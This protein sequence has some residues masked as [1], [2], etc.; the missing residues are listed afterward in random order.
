MA[1]RS[2]YESLL[3]RNS[4][5][6]RN[7]RTVSRSQGTTALPA[8]VQAQPLSVLEIGNGW[9]PERAGGLN[10]MFFN[11]NRHLPSVGIQPEGLTD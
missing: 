3:R 10:R 1:H 8:L 7:G 2:A 6:L 4:P 11:L 5:H 9:F